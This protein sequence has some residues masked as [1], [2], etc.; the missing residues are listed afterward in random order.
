MK[1]REKVITKLSPEGTVE[2]VTWKQRNLRLMVLPERPIYRIQNRKW[3][4]L[5]FPFD[6][7]EE[8][9][10]EKTA[11]MTFVIFIPPYPKQLER[12]IAEKLQKIVYYEDQ[13]AEIHQKAALSSLVRKI[14]TKAPQINLAGHMTCISSSQ[15]DLD[16]AFRFTNWS[17][18]PGE[19]LQVKIVWSSDDPDE[20]EIHAEITLLF[21]QRRIDENMILRTDKRGR[22]T[23]DIKKWNQEFCLEEIRAAETPELDVLK[24]PPMNTT[25]SSTE[26]ESKSPTDATNRPRKR[27]KLE[28]RFVISS[29]DEEPV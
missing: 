3:E 8:V 9:V 2:Q 17:I 10:H 1:I 21:D 20:G 19:L 24:T 27:Q 4:R 23:F 16:D 13:D 28:R 29:S 6:V 5:V 26:S 22:L 12:E 18:I 7:L 25:I 11:K 14:S 15:K